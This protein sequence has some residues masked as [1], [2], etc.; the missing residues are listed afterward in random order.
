MTYVI[1]T[2]R[3]L[4]GHLGGP[5]KL[6]IEHVG[7]LGAASA[8][9][10]AEVNARAKV[11]EKFL[12]T[13]ASWLPLIDKAIAETPTLPLIVMQG[14]KSRLKA[15]RVELVDKVTPAG[16]AVIHDYSISLH[17]VVRRIDEFLTGYCDALEAQLQI[18]QQMSARATLR[19]QLITLRDAFRT[20]VQATV[21]EVKETV[22]PG[23]PWWVIAVGAVAALGV[24]A[25]LGST[26]VTVV[27]K[28]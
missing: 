5:L 1:D 25:S 26:S 23:V 17:E 4:A 6:T 20:V 3:G 10:T 22:A 19:G 9:S 12:T 15:A 7:G 21:N 2:G 16:L 27:D 24:V 11:M 13:T 18:A 28:D 8:P 14:A